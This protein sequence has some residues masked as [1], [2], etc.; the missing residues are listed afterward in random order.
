MAFYE[1]LNQVI[2][3]LE[4]EGRI[5]YRALKR[6]FDLDDTTLEDVTHELVTVKKVAQEVDNEVLEL[7]SLEEVQILNK[8]KPN[9]NDKQAKLKESNQ[10]SNLVKED[11]ISQNKKAELQNGNKKTTKTKNILIWIGAAI[12]LIGVLLPWV[13]VRVNIAGSG[14]HNTT[15][16]GLDLSQGLLSIAAGIIGGILGIANNK[17]FTNKWLPVLILVA[18]IVVVGFTF[19]VINGVSRS[20]LGYGYSRGPNRIS[21]RQNPEIGVFITL[22]GGFLLIGGSLVSVFKK[23]KGV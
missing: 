13:A 15:A 1:L 10:Q 17:S 4:R 14:V 20:D 8:P 12:I 16:T 23:K 21:V 2:Q 19:D 6:E 5:S 9:T 7:I 11:T 3:L 22:I 18:G